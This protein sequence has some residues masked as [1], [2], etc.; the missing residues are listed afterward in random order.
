MC[1]ISESQKPFQGHY[2]HSAEFSYTWVVKKLKNIFTCAFKSVQPFPVNL[3]PP[4]NYI[5][6]VQQC[7][8]TF[9]KGFSHI[10][11]TILA[12]FNDNHTSNSVPTHIFLS[13]NL[14]CI[15][16]NQHKYKICMYSTCAMIS[17]MA[18]ASIKRMRKDDQVFHQQ[19]T[20][21]QCQT[22]NTWS[23]KTRAPLMKIYRFK[24]LYHPSCSL[25]SAVVH[26]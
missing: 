13:C 15:I 2:R 18:E 14:T 6:D 11:Y 10:M 23:L 24:I 4:I 16:T 12:L 1:F 3:C 9:C 26:L 8:H 17:S 25:P 5:H 7:H 19:M 22:S 21:T 20:P